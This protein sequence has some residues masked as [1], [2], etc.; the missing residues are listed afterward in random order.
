MKRTGAQWLKY[1]RLYT[2]DGFVTI[3]GSEL[4]VP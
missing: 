2:D 4:L 1:I 3:M